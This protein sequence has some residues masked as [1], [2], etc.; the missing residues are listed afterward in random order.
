[1][2]ACTT[3][4]T[5]QGFNRI[6]KEYSCCKIFRRELELSTTKFVTQTSNRFLIIFGFGV[7]VHL[8]DNHPFRGLETYWLGVLTRIPVTKNQQHEPSCNL[9]SLRALD[10]HIR[11]AHVH[12]LG[13]M[14]LKKITCL[15]PFKVQWGY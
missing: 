13:C 14:I 11:P 6:P 10:V 15:L 1:M 8:S 12:T 3:C 4:V 2:V 5:L 9:I 7:T